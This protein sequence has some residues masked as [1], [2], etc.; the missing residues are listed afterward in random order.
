[1]PSIY[2]L[3]FF[4]ALATSTQAVNS[5]LLTRVRATYEHIHAH[6]EIGNKEFETSKLIRAE[7]EQAGYT[8]FVDSPSLKTEVIAVLRTGRPGPTICLRAELDALAIAEETECEFISTVPGMMHAC[9]HDAHAAMLLGA[10]IELKNDP[11]VNG[12]IVFLFQPAE[13]VKGGAD[14]IINDSTL[15]KLGVEQVFAQHVFPGLPVGVIRI[16]PGPVLAGSNYYS[17]TVTGRGSHAAYPHQG[18][19]VPTCMANIIA[20]LTGLPARKM[21][22]LEEPCIMSVAWIECDT[23]KTYN[24][25]DEECSFGGTVRAY[26][27]IADSIQN[28]GTIESLMN[29][30]ITNTAEAYGCTA[31]LKLRRGAPPTTNDP[32]LC[33]AV[34]KAPDKF[35][36]LRADG[37]SIKRMTAEDFSYYTQTFPCLYFSLGVAKDG[38]GDVGLHQSKFSIHPDALEVG[39]NF[40][41]WLAR[42][43]TRTQ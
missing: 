2:F 32:A 41:I 24:V 22:V 7:L 5:T 42:W 43:S 10:A 9:G 33:E 1:M 38:L 28:G 12:N 36:A 40:L 39:T 29:D 18:D 34:L 25:L 17:V 15:Q 8:E 37:E 21:N 23:A 11:T 35:P 6:P 20:G 4:T 13:E 27:D 19:D 3:L 14:D 30:Y 16:A 31:E 26:F